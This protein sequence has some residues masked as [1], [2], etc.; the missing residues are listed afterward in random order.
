MLPAGFEPTIP[1]S[2]M[3]QTHA[4]ESAATGISLIAVFLY[5]MICSEDDKIFVETCWPVIL[6]DGNTY[7]Y[8]SCVDGNAVLFFIPGTS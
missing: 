3:P 7:K 1:A 8:G 5:G 4:L 6:S 2:E